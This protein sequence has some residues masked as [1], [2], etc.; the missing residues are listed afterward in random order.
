MVTT[1]STSKPLVRIRE[2]IVTRRKGLRKAL[3]TPLVCSVM[4]SIGVF[5]GMSALFVGAM[6]VVFHGVMKQD[7]LFSQVGT[8]LLIVA[9]PMILLGSVFLDEID[10]RK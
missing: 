4:A 7:V 3:L 10:L 8:V 1:N 5:G 9:I 2:D 6:C